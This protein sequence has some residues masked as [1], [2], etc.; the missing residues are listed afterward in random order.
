MPPFCYRILTQDPIQNNYSA[1]GLHAQLS[2]GF[3]KSV[4]AL[5]YENSGNC[6]LGMIQLELVSLIVT[7]QFVTEIT[8]SLRFYLANTVAWLVAFGAVR[9][10]SQELV[11]LSGCVCVE[12]PQVNQS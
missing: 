7:R 10:V 2:W 9:A 8:E 12:S 4:A 6:R 3:V 5:N 11:C 1:S